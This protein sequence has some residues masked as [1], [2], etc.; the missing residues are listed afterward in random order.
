MCTFT[1]FYKHDY[2]TNLKYLFMYP[3][4]TANNLYLFIIL[5]YVYDSKKIYEHKRINLYS[6]YYVYVYDSKLY[7]SILCICLRQ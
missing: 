1:T 6:L 7:H 3:F 2:E 4:A 5:L